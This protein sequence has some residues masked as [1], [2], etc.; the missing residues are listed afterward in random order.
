MTL[1]V[2]QFSF[3][4][5]KEN[6]SHKLPSKV[7][8]TLGGVRFIDACKFTYG[9]TTSSPI[10][11]EIENDTFLIFNTN[12]KLVSSGAFFIGIAEVTNAEYTEFVNWVKDS[13]AHSIMGHFK[14][15]GDQK[16]IDWNKKLD[17]DKGILL[18]QMFYNLDTQY[19][20]K[21]SLDSRKLVYSSGSYS[22]NPLNIYPDTL[23]WLKDGMNYDENFVRNY[24][25]HK[26]YKD[27]PVVGI[28]WEQAIAYCD[29]KSKVVNKLLNKLGYQEIEVRL[30]TEIEWEQ[31]IVQCIPN[32]DGWYWNNS[33]RRV[34]YPWQQDAGCFLVD[35]KGNYMANFGNIE[36]NNGE[37]L[38]NYNEDGYFFTSK[39][40]SFPAYDGIYDLAGN[41]DEWVL[42]NAKIEL[43][44]H[45]FNLK[46]NDSTFNKGIVELFGLD[47]DTNQLSNYIDSI[48]QTKNID[49]FERLIT[50]IFEALS[51]NEQDNMDRYRILYKTNLLLREFKIVNAGKKV[52]AKGGSWNSSLFDLSSGTRRAY[53]S[54]RG[55]S[56]VGFRIAF[57]PLQKKK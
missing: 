31:A 24:F 25:I 1:T 13:I 35:K 43:S 56:N 34:D 7:K 5:N 3:A 44:N 39:I 23:C 38:K 52:L 11:N 10:I 2:F 32:P 36:T 51:N 18:D 33:H 48:S 46:L 19:N 14:Y 42:S 16:Y 53:S 50:S 28:S 20:R 54:N 9:L 26:E 30:P 8:N 57:S 6:L 40:K 49:E 55:Y 45:I 15:V 17:W 21:R 12:R 47:M 29:W 41:V 37:R 27:H 22:E 4:Q